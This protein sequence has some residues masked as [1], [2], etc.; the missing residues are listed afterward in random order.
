MPDSYSSGGMLMAPDWQGAD[1]PANL[2]KR[3]TALT[4]D[5]HLHCSVSDTN[6]TQH[7]SRDLFF[8]AFAVMLA[9]TSD[10]IYGLRC[11]L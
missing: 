11:P 10:N 4:P 8:I 5:V 6:T 2:P 3:R 7:S 1:C 9:I